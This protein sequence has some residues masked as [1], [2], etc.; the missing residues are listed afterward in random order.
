MIFAAEGKD[1]RLAYRVQA[2]LNLAEGWEVMIDARTGEV[3]Q[4]LSIIQRKRHS[5]GH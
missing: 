4:Q 5:E 2:L 1:P 3:L